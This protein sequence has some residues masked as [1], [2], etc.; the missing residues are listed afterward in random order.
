MR[1]FQISKF[2]PWNFL[3]LIKTPYCAWGWW[4]ISVSPTGHIVSLDQ[5]LFWIYKEIVVVQWWCKI[6]PCSQFQCVKLSNSHY[7]GKWKLC[8]RMKNYTETKLEGKTSSKNI[9][10][11]NKKTRGCCTTSLTFL[12]LTNTANHHGT[13]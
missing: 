13:I 9:N 1:K 5:H 8:L 11:E 10:E 3:D 12:S 2:H 4:Y 7:T 6:H